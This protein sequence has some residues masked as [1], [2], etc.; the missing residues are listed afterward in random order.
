[1]STRALIVFALIAL[2]ASCGDSGSK[3]AVPTTGGGE[4]AP[5]VDPA[6]QKRRAE[7]AAQM[8]AAKLSDLRTQRTD[9]VI[10][11]KEAEEALRKLASRH[12]EELAN[13]PPKSKARRIYAQVKKDRNVKVSIL[14]TMESRLK[15][16]ERFAESDAAGDLKEL[17]VK[18][19]AVQKRYDDAQDSWRTALVESQQGVVDVSPVKHELDT[20]RLMKVKWIES[21]PTARR[22]NASGSAKKIINDGFRSWLGERGDRKAVCGKV[23]KRKG[24]QSPDGYDFTNLEFFLLLELLEDELDRQNVAVEKKELKK[25]EALLDGIA[26]ELDA[27]DDEISQ[28]MQK[29]GP[30]FE[31]FLDLKSRIGVV[32]K[33][34][35]QLENQFEAWAQ[36]LDEAMTASERQ[37]EESEAADLV[38][39]TARRQLKDID[40][41]IKS[42]GG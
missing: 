23:L 8:R 15:E 14:K 32:R 25:N 36:L 18:R 12:E 10:Q 31:E 3:P 30:E 17:Q 27:V 7:E 4:Q 6:E 39:T 42:L 38:L 40:R 24:G 1:M 34:A 29:A 33:T 22:G 11:V 41:Q 19:K 20:L 26:T 21:T 37:A 28:R 16:L 13:L 2:V 5:P 35:D 9:L